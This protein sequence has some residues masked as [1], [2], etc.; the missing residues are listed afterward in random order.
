VPGAGTV[1]AAERDEERRRRSAHV[2]WRYRT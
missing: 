2:A 1:T